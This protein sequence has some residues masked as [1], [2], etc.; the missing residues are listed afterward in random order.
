[1]GIDQVMSV[2][3]M[4]GQFPFKYGQLVCTGSASRKDGY[5][6]GQDMK[7]VQQAVNTGQFPSLRTKAKRVYFEKGHVI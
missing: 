4:T 2:M 7:Y 5:S 1:M 6:I 3:F